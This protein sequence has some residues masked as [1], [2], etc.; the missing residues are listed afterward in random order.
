MR[1]STTLAIVVMIAG[2]AAGKLNL[3]NYKRCLK[4]LSKSSSI[5]FPRSSLIQKVCTVEENSTESYNSQS[6]NVLP[7]ICLVSLAMA[8]SMRRSV[9]GVGTVNNQG[10][11]DGNVGNK[12]RLI[13]KSNSALAYLN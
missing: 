12:I 6:P 3:F 7:E 1:M 2:V 13:T 11:N 9:Y 5:F 10:A 8:S 4:I